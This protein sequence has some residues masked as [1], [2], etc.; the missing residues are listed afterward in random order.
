VIVI[1]EKKNE[2][3]LVELEVK[4]RRIGAQRR[5]ENCGFVA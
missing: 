2:M 5:D 1:K 4:E 3:K